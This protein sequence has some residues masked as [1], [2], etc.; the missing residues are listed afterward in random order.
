MQQLGAGHERTIDM[1]HA[2]VHMPHATCQLSA[3]PSPCSGPLLVSGPSSVGVRALKPYT[4]RAPPARGRTS[5]C[6]SLMAYRHACRDMVPVGCARRCRT[7]LRCTP[8]QICDRWTG[9]AAH[10]P[11]MLFSRWSR[12]EE[13]CLKHTH[14]HNRAS[15]AQHEL[16]LS[17]A[18][19]E[20]RPAF[21]SPKLYSRASC[22]QV[23][24]T[25][26]RPLL[27]ASMVMRCA[28]LRVTVRTT[29]TIVSIT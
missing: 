18:M 19:D 13:D 28:F 8:I 27:C 2:T 23:V 21:C 3:A 16:L 12:R 10:R 6:D 7:R 4:P 29:D 17:G 26:A 25:V 24:V 22:F 11:T 9:A 14:A 5:S 20:V 1:R 15:L